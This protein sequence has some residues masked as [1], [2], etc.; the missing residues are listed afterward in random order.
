MYI[1]IYI[2]TYLHMRRLSRGA[3][4]GAGVARDLRAAQ[5]GGSVVVIPNILS[6]IICINIV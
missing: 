2:H 1:Y 6:I 3:W 5:R 4:Q